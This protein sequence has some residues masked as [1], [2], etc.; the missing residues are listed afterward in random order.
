MEVLPKSTSLMNF[1]GYQ[2]HSMFIFSVSEYVVRIDVSTMIR[3]PLLCPGSLMKDCCSGKD[4]IE[5]SPSMLKEFRNKTLQWVSQI[6]V[7]LSM[8]VRC[9]AGNSFYVSV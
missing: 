2:T 9:R 6:L 7:P 4:Q 3:I 8:S 5:V 1:F